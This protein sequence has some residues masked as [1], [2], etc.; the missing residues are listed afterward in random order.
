[1]SDADSA[2]IAKHLD[3]IEHS[4]RRLV[5]VMTTFNEN[6]VALVNKLGEM[7]STELTIDEAHNYIAGTDTLQKD[8]ESF[9]NQKEE[10]DGE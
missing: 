6:F 9:K 10:S 4:M 2:R 1:M 3:S 5:A 8:Y 7:N